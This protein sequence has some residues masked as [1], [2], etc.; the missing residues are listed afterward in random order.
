MSKTI[1]MHYINYVL[2]SID[3]NTYRN[4]MF[5]MLKLYHN[6][7]ICQVTQNSWIVS[8]YC[9][10]NFKKTS[11]KINIVYLTRL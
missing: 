11:P 9:R 8:T 7:I 4:I 3:L 10:K 5:S 2:M 6:D 1:K